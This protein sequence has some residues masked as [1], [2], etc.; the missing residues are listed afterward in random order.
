MGAGRSWVAGLLWVSAGWSQTAPPSAPDA[1]LAKVRAAYY[2]ETRERMD[3]FTAALAPDWTA[4]LKD[5]SLT[6]AARA[7]ALGRLNAI[8]FALAL[9]RRGTPVITHRA[10]ATADPQQSAAMKQIYDGMEQMISG[11]FQT[12]I[13][14]MI[15]PPVPQAGTPYHLETTGPW[16]ILSYNEG[17]TK[18]EVTL[19]Q[20]LAAAEVRVVNKDFTSSIHPSFEKTAKGLVLVG[21]QATYRSTQAS[22]ETDLDVK[23]Q[24]QDVDGCTLPRVLDLGGTYGRAPFHVLVTFSDGH[25]TKF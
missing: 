10:P 7:E 25:V 19:G 12:W 17:G 8:Q 21:Y 24:N 1:F 4:L 13:I 16:Q 15:Q 18:V 23:I 20:D 2:S 3:R 5:Q 14:F 22:E 6:P 11:F 9:D